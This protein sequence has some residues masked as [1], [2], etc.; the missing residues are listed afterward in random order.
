MGHLGEAAGTHLV[1][2]AVELVPSLRDAVAIVAIHHEDQTLRVLEVVPPEGANL[3][4]T[5]RRRGKKKSVT[6]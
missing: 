4:E 5:R 1:E 6:G 2:H 3:G